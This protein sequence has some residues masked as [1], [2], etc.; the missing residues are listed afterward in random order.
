MNQAV[1]TDLKI[2]ETA[3]GNVYHALKKSDPTFK[4]FGEAYFSSVNF[5]EIK[6]W[7][8]HTQM[9]LNLVVIVGEVRFVT[10]NGSEFKEYRLSRSNYK[11]LTVPKGL[12]MAF[13]GLS[14]SENLLLNIADIEHDPNESLNKDLG[15]IKYEW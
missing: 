2:I 12:W 3:K 15:E 10:Y 8:Q 14:K 4:N 9:T 6:G 11:R 13:Q 7:K 5:Q 1:L